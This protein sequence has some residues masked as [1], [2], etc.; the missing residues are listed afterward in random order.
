MKNIFN[1][2]VPRLVAAA[3][4]MF[5]SLVSNISHAA[6][7]T[8][9]AVYLQSDPG[10]YVGGGIGA[11]NVTWI[12]GVDGIFSSSSIGPGKALISYQGSAYWSFDFAAPTYNPQTNT[13]TGTPLQVGMYL[14]ATRYPFNSP[15]RPGMS[16]SGNGRGNN[17]SNGWFNV[18]DV[19]FDG[20]GNLLRLAVD[21]KQY[22]ETTTMSG[23]GIFGSL[24]YNAPGIALNTTG[25]AS[26][27][28][29][30]AAWLFGSGLLGLIG[31]ARRKTT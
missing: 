1:K 24:R 27:P 20:S 8:N 13:T 14:N 10:S 22:D 16:I 23:P 3:L 2:K 25:V 4:F 28:V 26:V 30:A 5:G 15:T 21:F 31:M 6:L 29:P 19:A 7:A 18:L 12:H 17:V 9:A 11:Q